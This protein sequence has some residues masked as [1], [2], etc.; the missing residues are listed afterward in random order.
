MTELVEPVDWDLARRVARRVA[1]RAGTLDPV[2]A[3]DL[4]QS[5]TDLT[6]R[7]EDLVAEHTGLRSAHGPARSA[8]LE[9]TDWA[10]A[11]VESFR[12][13]LAPVTA[14]LARQMPAR[15]GPVRAARSL[16]G[17]E[18]G[19]LLGWM[20]S[21][22]LGQYDLLL[23]DQGAGGG[24]VWYVG[25]NVVSLERRFGF[26]PQ[27]FRLWL[28]VHELTHRAQFTGVPWL[29]DTYLGLVRELT[30]SFDPDPQRL[31]ASLRE[32][33]SSTRGE[34]GWSLSDGGLAAVLATPHQRDV[35]ARI[36]GLM[37]LLEGHGDATMARVGAAVIPGSDRFA[38]VLGHRR[39]NR[40]TPSKLLHRLI[41]LEAKLA[42]YA[43]GER[44]VAAVEA[45]HGHRGV[46]L[47]WSAPEAL[48]SL[49]EIREPERWL[50]RMAAAAA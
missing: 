4:H 25:P 23:A 38:K 34:A 20:S 3:A 47:C 1:G 49:A 42:Q 44:F 7:A 18:V 24:Q 19:A 22:V 10:E 17:A 39:A 30:E 31:L 33:R 29:R 40:P 50:E 13:L 35:M 28:A 37:S 21:R 32:A 14:K 6:A 36:G 27:H 46:D 11:N 41:G 12:H 16:T 15:Q 8:V 45:E 9:R 26:E 43:Q 2:D 5:F 48:P